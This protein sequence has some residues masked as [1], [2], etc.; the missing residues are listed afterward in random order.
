MVPPL[1]S[2][3]AATTFFR[4]RCP[5]GVGEAA[6]VYDALAQTPFVNLYATASPL[7]D[8]A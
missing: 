3:V 6:T 2:S 1:A 4:G 8:L 5:L 7:E